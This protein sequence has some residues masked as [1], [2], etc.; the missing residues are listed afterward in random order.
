VTTRVLQHLLDHIVYSPAFQEKRNFNFNIVCDL[1]NRCTTIEDIQ[2]QYPNVI[3]RYKKG[4]IN[5]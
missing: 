1:E 4:I 3:K 2:E 5:T